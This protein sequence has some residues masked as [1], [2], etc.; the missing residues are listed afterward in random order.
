MPSK[1]PDRLREQIQWIIAQS[2]LKEGPREGFRVSFDRV[3]VSRCELS[4]DHRQCRVFVRWL[5][6][7][8]SP[9]QKKAVLIALQKY[10]GSLR[11][12]LAK[13][14]RIKRTPELSFFWDDGIEHQE[15][16]E[17]LFDEIKR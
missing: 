5:D 16:M 3:V 17:A 6:L 4:P 13:N 10:Q 15:R 14:L 1:H 12:A 7:D 8:V 2:L 9:A 11:K